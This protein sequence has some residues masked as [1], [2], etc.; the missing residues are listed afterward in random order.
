[1]HILGQMWC[2]KERGRAVAPQSSLRHG[3]WSLARSP[4]SS[5]CLGLSESEQNPIFSPVVR[6]SDSRIEQWSEILCPSQTLSGRRE[7][8]LARPWVWGR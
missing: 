1:M 7:G 4:A 8:S 5:I 3:R 2:G 6:R